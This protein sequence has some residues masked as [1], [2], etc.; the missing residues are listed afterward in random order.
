MSEMISNNLKNTN[1]CLD[2][3]S[4]EMTEITKS[5]ECTQ[6]QL[7]EE[8]KNIK[9]NIRNLGTSMKGIKEDLLDPDDAFSKL[10][11]LEDIWK[12]SNLHEGNEETQNQT[13]EDCE[14]K[15]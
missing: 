14:T 12:R 9:E 2:E 4:K 10:I 6:D 8:I 15:I 1:D 5:L 11:E 3:I 7:E 13:W